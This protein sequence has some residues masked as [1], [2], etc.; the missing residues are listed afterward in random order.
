[1]IDNEIKHSLAQTITQLTDFVETR[2]TL[3]DP[4]AGFAHYIRALSF[5]GKTPAY[6]APEWP[7]HITLRHPQELACFGYLIGV[8]DQYE[9]SLHSNWIGSCERILSR[10]AFPIDR[11]SFAFRPIEVLGIAH[12]LT[13][14]SHGED[15]CLESFRS[16][17][18][19]CQTKANSD[20]WSRLVYWTAA[21]TIGLADYPLTI[22]TATEWNLD[23]AALTKWLSM[24]FTKSHAFSD[25]VICEA[26]ARIIRDSSVGEFTLDNVGQAALLWATLTQCVV[27]RID[28]RLSQTAVVSAD[29]QH[30][31]DTVITICRRFPLFA[32]QL[33]ERR[34]DIKGET[35]KERLPRPTIEMTDEYDVQDSL[36]AVL[37]LFFDDIRPETWTPDYGGNQNRVDFLLPLEEI[38]IEAKHMGSRLTQRDVAEQLIIDERYYRQDPS[39]KHLVCLVYDPELRCKNP[40]ALESDLSKQED[41]FAIIVIVCPQGV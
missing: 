28:A 5:E 7:V 34:K 2:L 16:V 30:A 41:D 40:V 11:Q 22:P 15:T 36:H 24:Q 39:C 37:R 23:D 26:E 9:P 6:V 32:R 12:G 33:Q 10:D 19:D 35:P 20:T 29:A 18:R 14:C 25:E 1:M 27:R 4:N 3:P 13:K 8:D 31:I 38:V 17:L 21:Q